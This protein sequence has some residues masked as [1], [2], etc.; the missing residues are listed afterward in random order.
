MLAANNIYGLLKCINKNNIIIA[1]TQLLMLLFGKE[2]R[3]HI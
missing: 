1:K 2:E 3:N